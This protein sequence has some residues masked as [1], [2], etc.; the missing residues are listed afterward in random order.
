MTIAS[1]IAVNLYVISDVKGHPG[2]Y[3]VMN[4]TQRAGTVVVLSG[5]IASD[6]PHREV[7]AFS[8]GV[9]EDDV[10]F[11]GIDKELKSYYIA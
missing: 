3:D 6:T 8:A 10:R 11:L 4:L 2:I 9:S 5:G 7:A 1:P